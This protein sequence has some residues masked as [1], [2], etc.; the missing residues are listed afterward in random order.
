MIQ[1]TGAEK[2][3]YIR[4]NGGGIDVSTVILL[5]TT[6]QL[7]GDHLTPLVTSLASTNYYVAEFNVPASSADNVEH[8]A[9]SHATT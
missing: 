6:Y 7:S 8:P 5:S 3:T 4:G 2:S 9:G 1:H